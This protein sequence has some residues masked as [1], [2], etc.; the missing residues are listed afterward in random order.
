MTFS[1]MKLQETKGNSRE[2]QRE[3][4][5]KGNEEGIKEWVEAAGHQVCPC[6]V[7]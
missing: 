1:L 2:R 4:G 5:R 3:E 7:G 6:L